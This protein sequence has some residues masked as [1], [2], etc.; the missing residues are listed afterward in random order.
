ML[1]TRRPKWFLIFAFFG[2]KSTGCVI[3]A[4]VGGWWPQTPSVGNYFGIGIGTGLV[5]RKLHPFCQCHNNQTNG[6]HSRDSQ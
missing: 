5:P 1:A 4:A 6:K 3:A 2:C